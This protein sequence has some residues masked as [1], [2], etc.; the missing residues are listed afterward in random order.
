MKKLNLK[1]QGKKKKRK[2]KPKPYKQMTFPGERIQIDVKTVP[3]KCIR[4]PVQ[5]ISIHRY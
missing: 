4:R 3:S 5:I 1:F 2:R